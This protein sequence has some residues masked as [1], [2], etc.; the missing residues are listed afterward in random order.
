MYIE[1]FSPDI[2]YIKS[3][4]CLFHLIWLSS[5]V[6]FHSKFSDWYTLKKIMTEEYI[7]IPFPFFLRYRENNISFELIAAAK[8]VIDSLLLINILTQKIIFLNYFVTN[9]NIT[10]T[11]RSINSFMPFCNSS[12]NVTEALTTFFVVFQKKVKY[13]WS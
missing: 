7:R 8:C 6:Y 11:F 5:D 12:K 9:V 10:G 13:F 2:I 1:I 3:I 4:L